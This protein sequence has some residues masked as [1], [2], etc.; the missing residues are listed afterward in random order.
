MTSG[1]GYHQKPRDSLE[2]R[3]VKGPELFGIARDIDDSGSLSVNGIIRAIP[4][5]SE[6]MIDKRKLKDRPS[7]KL[8]NRGQVSSALS[9]SSKKYIETKDLR[10]WEQE[11]LDT[12]NGRG[13]DRIEMDWRDF[14]PRVINSRG[15]YIG[16]LIVKKS[17]SYFGQLSSANEIA[18]MSLRHESRAD[19]ND[20]RSALQPRI[21]LYRASSEE[22]AWQTM[23][24]VGQ[25]LAA[26]SAELILSPAR[27]YKVGA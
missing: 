7:Q 21:D 25:L 19:S 15:K 12:V 23:E 10:R 20:Q 16:S 6:Y 13:H 8:L 9:R 11:I 24:K 5:L 27:G 1:C 3:R 14:E 26:E 17:S 18:L 22:V 2:R 4:R